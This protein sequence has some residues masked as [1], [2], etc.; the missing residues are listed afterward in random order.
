MSLA[1]IVSAVEKSGTWTKRYSTRTEWIEEAAR[2]SGYGLR[3]IYRMLKVKGFLDMMVE[4][5]K[6]YLPE[7][8]DIPLASI[9]IIQRMHPLSEAKAS[10]LLDQAIHGRVTLKEVQTVYDDIVSQ[11]LEKAGKKK[12]LPRLVHSFSESA[13]QAVMQNTQLFIGK[14]KFKTVREF[15]GPYGFVLDL[16][17]I[18]SAPTPS[19]IGFEF[20]YFREKPAQ[21]KSVHGLLHEVAFLSQFFRIFWIVFD[22]DAGKKVS[23]YISEGLKKLQLYN[24]GIALVKPIAESS[25]NQIELKFANSIYHPECI[26]P[27]EYGFFPTQ[28]EY[29]PRWENLMLDHIRS[30]PGDFLSK[31]KGKSN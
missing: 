29:S 2:V 9:E 30:M 14:G 24:V 28:K 3:V 21:R 13:V 23:E 15:R 19:V 1:E 16:I 25:T 17:V 12:V 27:H 8:A 18:K 10:Q 31:E 4:K 7:G 20:K 5:G 6:V 22:A 26:S 11:N